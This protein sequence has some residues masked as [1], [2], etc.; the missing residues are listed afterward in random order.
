MTAP[1]SFARR[2]FFGRRAEQP[3]AVRTPDAAGS[4]I[5]TPQIKRPFRLLSIDGG[6]IR[7]LIPAM[8]LADLERRTNRPIIDLFDMIVGTSTGG[9]LGLALSTP[10]EN[11]R[12]RHTARDIVRL[13]EQEG[14]RVFSR[15][16]WHK[17]RAVGNLAD[18]K[19]PSSGLESVLDD[20]FG[21][22]R[23]K[24]A[25]AE[26]IVPAYEIER[27][28]PFFFKTSNA[29]AKAYYDYP[30]K[31][32]IR[33]ATAAPTY[34]EPMQIQVDG[35]NDYYALVDG[36]LFAYNPAM[37]A[38]VEVLNRFPEYENITMVSL[39]TGELTRRLPYDEVKDWGAA[40]W[41]QPTF[42][43][44][45]DGICDVVDYQLQQLL[46][47]LPDGRR[48]YFRFQSRLDI[49]NDDMDDASNTNIR[50]LKLVGQD[51]LQA[52]RMVLRSLSEQLLAWA[53]PRADAPPP[54][55]ASDAP[56]T[57][58][59][60]QLQRPPV[61]VGAV[62]IDSA[63]IARIEARRLL[64]P[65]TSLSCRIRVGRYPGFF[66]VPG[67]P[68]CPRLSFLPLPTIQPL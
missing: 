20:Y 39:G 48:Q 4:L 21:E 64:Q 8:V 13:Y 49:G 36:A 53:P 46:P 43:M 50:V 35:P 10:G 9:L 51:M 44:M 27:R 24:D 59:Q 28:F 66:I 15:S 62:P 67:M 17:I 19:Y 37:C 1:F 42:A 38:Y 55:T 16:V 5:S 52:N 30:M 18:G 68:S 61:P 34:F 26:V 29:R 58:E 57:E 31:D 45:C 56:V 33:A 22:T 54:D 47:D 2:L 12:P 63:G 23:L 41:A 3:R 40:R 6:G 60:V 14:R 25:L 7:G 65:V 11:G 32:V